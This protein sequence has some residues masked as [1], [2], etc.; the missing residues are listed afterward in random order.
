[1]RNLIL[2]QASLLFTSPTTALLLSS[3]A[4][5]TPAACATAASPTASETHRRRRQPPPEASPAGTQLPKTLPSRFS[6]ACEIG[7]IPELRRCTPCCSSL[8]FV[9]SDRSDLDCRHDVI[10]ARREHCPR[11]QLLPRFSAQS[12]DSPAASS[13]GFSVSDWRYVIGEDRRVWCCSGCNRTR[14]V[15]VKYLLDFLITNQR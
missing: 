9:S 6:P 1:M 10:A 5:K 12:S 11:C 3:R 7:R 14:R 13:R 2:I 15:V 4:T 8:V